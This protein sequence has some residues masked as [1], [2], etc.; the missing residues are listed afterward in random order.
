MT[1]ARG[2]V[3][4][5]ALVLIACGLA[6]TMAPPAWSAETQKKVVRFEYGKDKAAWFWQHQID[7]E[8]APP[9]PPPDPIPDPTGGRIRFPNPQ[10][11]DTLPV[12]VVN[13]E[14]DRVSAL[15]FDVFSRG[16]TLGS[17][18]TRFVV[19][20][21]EGT[22]RNE[23]PSFNEESA[24]IE[25]C[26]NAE[27][28][29]ESGQPPDQWESRPDVDDSAC[30]EGKRKASGDTAKWTFD[31]TDLAEP[32]GED[33]FSNFGVTLLGI[34]GEG[35][36]PADSWQVN[37]KIPAR[38]RDPGP[39][40]PEDR[41]DY[42]ETRNR[43]R[44]DLA[45]VPGEPIVAP[46]PPPPPPAVSDVAGTG[47]DST[48]D[49]TSVEG[50][51]DQTPTFTEAGSD[52]PAQ[53]ASTPVAANLPRPRMPGYVWALLPIG[54]LALGAVRSVVVDPAGG[55]RPDGVIASIRRRNSERRGAS[56][57]QPRDPY[58][59]VWAAT[60]RS[61]RGLG[62]SFSNAKQFFSTSVRSVKKR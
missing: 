49:F 22:D 15:Q 60:R 45:F 34:I 17:E 18:I 21:E 39:L 3:G 61:L 6:L 25:A 54:L 30:V 47:F 48:T 52:V 19:T 26:R 7:E 5:A 59:T 9:Q 51:N 55:T 44:V 4:R 20:I 31:L 37:L 1:R 62:R 13:G 8:V 29:A 57:R 36:G 24:R 33:P 58:A 28:F 14:H 12:A 56:L 11:P 10:Q 53:P 35:S 27:F 50:F 43:V 32:W 16:V 41:D 46:L 2:V 23:Q 38:D 40:E 42:K